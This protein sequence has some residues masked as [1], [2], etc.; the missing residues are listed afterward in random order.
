MLKFSAL[1]IILD[2]W[3]FKRWTKFIR[4][5]SY[6]KLF[7]Q[8]PLWISLALVP[9]AFYVSY[10]KIFNILTTSIDNIFFSVITLWYVPK[11]IIVPIQLLMDIPRYLYFTKNFLEKNYLFFKRNLKKLFGVLFAFKSL[12]QFRMNLDRSLVFETNVEIDFLEKFNDN[13]S[14]EQASIMFK[15]RNE[16]GNN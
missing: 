3:F 8:I 12:P 4:V 6:N 13:N 9:V 7:Y 10:I 11:L 16:L 5:H 14:E 1:F 2:F 15:K